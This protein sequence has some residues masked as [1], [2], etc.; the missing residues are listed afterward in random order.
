MES[1]TNYFLYENLNFKDR[2]LTSLSLSN[3]EK[4]SNILSTDSISTRKTCK[5]KI[6]YFTY[7]YRVS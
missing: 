1:K 6:I 7:S 3:H 5:Q 2:S 4:K